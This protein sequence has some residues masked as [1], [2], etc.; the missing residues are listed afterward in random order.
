M[1]NLEIPEVRHSLSA[2]SELC[3]GRS[4]VCPELA[5]VV[6]HFDEK[7]ASYEYRYM[8]Q[9][10]KYELPNLMDVFNA[11]SSLDLAVDMA[12]GASASEGRAP[13]G[14]WLVPAELAFWRIAPQ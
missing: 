12:I 9:D 2:L 1:Q 5:F 13:G 3:V 10:S 7:H 14:A 11:F 4:L 6:S 8:Q